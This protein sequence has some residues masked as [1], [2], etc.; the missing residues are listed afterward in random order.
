MERI[1]THCHAVLAEDTKA[2]WC[3]ACGG[4]L[5]ERAGLPASA[6]K[7]AAAEVDHRGIVLPRRHAL[8][9]IITPQ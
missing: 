9:G 2:D 1:C 3:P 4:A 5:M 7:A 6:A 8:G